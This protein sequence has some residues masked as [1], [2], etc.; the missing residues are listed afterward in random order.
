MTSTGSLLVTNFGTASVSIVDT[1]SGTITHTLKTSGRPV[2]VDVSADG[3]RG[4]VTVFGPDSL[5]VAPNP[6]TLQS[7]DLTSAIGTQPGSVVVLDTATGLAV[8]APISVGAA[9]PTSV[10]VE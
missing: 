5:S 1:T 7:G 6:L 9:G 2:G 4:Y 10:V 8:G 3:T